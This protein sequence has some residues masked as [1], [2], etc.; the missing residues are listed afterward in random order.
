MPHARP[1]TRLIAAL[2]TRPVPVAAAPARAPLRYRPGFRGRWLPGLLTTWLV[3]LTC[4]TAAA[5]QEVL[6][7]PWRGRCRGGSRRPVRSTGA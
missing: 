3:A 1:G 7:G 5:V 4:L 6:P 2:G